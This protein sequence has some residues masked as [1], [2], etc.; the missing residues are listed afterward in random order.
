MKAFHID[1]QQPRTRRRLAL[2]VLASTLQLALERAANAR[3][4]F[5]IFG[6]KQI[7]K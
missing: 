7:K 5:L 3:P 1:M 2:G 6:W 4:G